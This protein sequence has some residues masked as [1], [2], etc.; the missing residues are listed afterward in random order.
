[1]IIF[2][3]RKFPDIDNFCP[4]IDH[5]AKKNIKIRIFSLNFYDD[6]SKNYRI[7]YLLK[8]YTCVEFNNFKDLIVLNFYQNYLI[9][10]E[11]SFLNK[12]LIDKFIY[13]ILQKFGIFNAIRDFFFKDK[14]LF[15]KDSSVKTLVIDHLT[16][17]K[18]FYFNLIFKNLKKKKIKIVS[19]PSGLPLY[20][21][22]PKPWNQAKHEI[23]NLSYK[24]DNIVIQHKYWLKEINNFKKINNNFKILGSIRY[25]QSWRKTLLKIKKDRIYKKQKNKI[26]IVYMDSNNP[27]HIDFIELKQKTLDLIS[28]NDKFEVKFKPHPRSNKIY[29]KLNKNIEV[30]EKEDSLNLINWADVVLGD[31]SA[32]MIETLL[33]NKRYIS[34]SYLR[35][36]NNIMLYDKYDI[37]EECNDIKDLNRMILIGIKLNEK[38]LFKKN[39][40]RFMDDFVYYPQKDVLN[41]YEK[42]IIN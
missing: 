20:L 39:L 29:I 21:I 8:K 19:I 13:K 14:N 27:N 38:K 11:Y 34:L 5:L 7:K 31:I 12:K 22:H 35:K 28:K 18:L 36:K 30:C 41:E 42:I 37:C 26:N 3:I 1:M 32:I 17:E 16:P 40:K 10:L 4:L 25:V 9:N 24:V 2:T 15:F 23:S 6:L 33:Q